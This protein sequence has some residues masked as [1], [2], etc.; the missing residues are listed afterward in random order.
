MD[1]I[2]FFSI[3]IPVYNVE[4][5]LCQCIDSIIKQDYNNIEIILVDDGSPD[6]CPQICDDYAFKHENIKVIHKQNGGLS[7][8]RNVGILEAKGRYLVFVDSDDWLNHDA[9]KIAQR[10]I[11]KY[12]NPDVLMSRIKIYQDDTNEET[13]CLYYFDEDELNVK[14][15]AE[16]YEICTE[17][18]GFWASAWMFIVRREYLLEK[19]LFFVKGLLHEDEQWSPKLIL[20]SRTI[21]FNNHC[22]YYARS[23][24]LGSITFDVNIKRELDKL[25][26]ID[27]LYNESKKKQ[28]DE[29]EKLAL[30]RR[31]SSIFVGVFLSTFQ[32]KSI[33][34]E[35]FNILVEGLKTRR[36]V[37]KYGLGMKYKILFVICLTLGTRNAVLVFN[38]IGLIG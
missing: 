28:Y 8:A 16:T 32:Y 24:R 1:I 10:A 18:P 35:Q 20:N 2:P 30:V 31:C 27:D 21:G 5:Y 23:N 4:K 33:S 15:A 22:F 3:I 26:I 7:D 6:L 14:S 37:L 29:A 9:L 12:S 11:D 25:L 34:K 17:L 36:Y 38:K 13:E 19:N